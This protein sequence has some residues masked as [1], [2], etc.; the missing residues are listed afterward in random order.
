MPFP[1]QIFWSTL[2]IE[3]VASCMLFDAADDG[4]YSL[5]ST[6]LTGLITA[7]LCCACVIVCRQI[8]RWGN[9]RDRRKGPLTRLARR[10]AK[11]W[12]RWRRGE[13]PASAPAPGWGSAPA[14]GSTPA[15]APAPPSGSSLGRSAVGA[16]GELLAKKQ[17]EQKRRRAVHTTRWL[18]AWLLNWGVFVAAECLVVVYGGLFGPEKTAAC[19]EAWLFSSGFMWIAIEPL[20]V[21]VLAMMP[22]L[23]DS[24]K[25]AWL[26]WCYNNVLAC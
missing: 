26:R 5:V 4:G 10:L 9:R 14:S 6:A 24:K 21:V 15:P 2:T 19:F 11:R 22:A 7:G 20:Q 1:S 8:F 18:V 16:P 13:A 23:M 12:R 3:L 17:K 25:L